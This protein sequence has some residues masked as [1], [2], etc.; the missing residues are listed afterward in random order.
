[1]NQSWRVRTFIVASVT[2][3]LVLWSP[4]V[5]AA[6]QT[7]FAKLADV[8]LEIEKAIAE[9]RTVSDQPPLFIIQ[10]VELKLQGKWQTA[11][12]GT[13]SFTIPIF[14]YGADL[15]AKGDQSQEDKL[16]LELIP[17][18][19]A[20]VGGTNSIDFA[21]VIRLL[22]ST[23]KNTELLP[24]KVKYSHNWALQLNAGGNINVAIAKA[25]LKIAQENAQEVTFHLCH[26]IN[27]VD[28]TE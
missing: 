22:K 8:E 16:S 21:S 12:D 18:N 5:A 4:L 20:P 15:S 23:F 2:G 13:V 3:L 27:R 10:K 17:R 6:Q 14:K 9:A 7:G 11:G 25:G 1:M 28:C 24:A 19:R 26:T